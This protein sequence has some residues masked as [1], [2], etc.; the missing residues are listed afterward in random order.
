MAYMTH[1][2][3]IKVVHTGEWGAGE[4]LVL[5][6]VACCGISFSRSL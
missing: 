4:I 5:V 2:P 6:F 3:S 1:G